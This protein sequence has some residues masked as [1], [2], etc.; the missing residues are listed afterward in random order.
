MNNNEL[1]DYG[2]LFAQDSAK[3]VARFFQSPTA[4]YIGLPTEKDV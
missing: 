1:I 3:F 2:L 4:T